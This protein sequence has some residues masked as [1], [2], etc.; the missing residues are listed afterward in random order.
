MDY[1][2]LHRLESAIWGSTESGSPIQL[3]LEPIGRHTPLKANFKEETTTRRGTPSLHPSRAFARKHGLQIPAQTTPGFLFLA[4]G[5]DEL[6][7]KGES[8]RRL[9]RWY[10]EPGC[11]WRLTITARH[12]KRDKESDLYEIDP[13]SIR[14]GSLSGS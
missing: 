14:R 7:G 8:Q 10:L 12:I 4:F 9:Q 3:S 5:M 6:I 1:A 2:T 13:C 11:S